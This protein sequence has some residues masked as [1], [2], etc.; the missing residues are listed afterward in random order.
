MIASVRRH[1]VVAAVVVTY[2]VVLGVYGVVSGSRLA[3]PYVVIVAVA[4]LGLARAED[5]FRFS[6]IV[7][8]GLTLWG[9]GHLA[10]GIIELD[11]GDR[12]FYNVVLGRWFHMDNVVHFIGFGTAG[13]ACWEALRAGWLG[14]V[15][16]GPIATVAYIAILGC[17][18]GAINEVLEFA[19][20]LAVANTQVG[21]YQNTGRDLVANL[22][23]GLTAGVY[24]VTRV[25]RTEVA[26]TA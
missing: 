6:R 24:Q 12:I 8:V 18:V 17:G 15:E 22:L 5:R 23:G 16:V 14:D 13:L 25:K 26:R 11:G 2:L 4:F 21:G 1:P 20:T 9:L 3:V 19:Y 7:L 10:G